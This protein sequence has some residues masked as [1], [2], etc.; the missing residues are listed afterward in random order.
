MLCMAYKGT[1]ASDLFY[2]YQGIDGNARLEIDLITAAEIG[3][4]IS[5]ATNEAKGSARAKAAV[6]KRDKRRAARKQLSNKD[7]FSMLSESGV[8][9]KDGRSEG[10]TE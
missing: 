7:I 4:R 5:K 8:P 9:I 3:D 6:A 2:K 10:V 1:L